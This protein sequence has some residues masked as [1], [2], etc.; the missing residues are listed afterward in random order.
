MLPALLVPL[1]APVLLPAAPVV[2][3]VCAPQPVCGPPQTALPGKPQPGGPICPTAPAY[4]GLAYVVFE[5][6]DI[7]A[8]GNRPPNLSFEVFR[9]PKGAFN[10]LESRIEGVCLIPGAG[11]FIYATT[12]NAVL[13]GLTRATSETHHTG[14]GISDFQVIAG[15]RKCFEPVGRIG[16]SDDIRFF[17]MLTVNRQSERER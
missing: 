14:Y 6:L 11:E 16:I 13:T 8:F 5:A 2:P 7:T 9:R 12:A 15:D 3:A 1:D 17:K 4:R 10:D